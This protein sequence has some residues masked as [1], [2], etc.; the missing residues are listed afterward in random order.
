MATTANYERSLE[1]VAFSTAQ[2]RILTEVIEESGSER[3]RQLRAWMEERF[4]TKENAARMQGS[5]ELKISEMKSELGSKVGEAQ[6]GLEGKIGEV[7]RSLEARIGE[8][9]EDFQKQSAD[10][11]RWIFLF[12]IGQFAALAAILKLFK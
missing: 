8:V 2:A 7:Q 1:E 9:R 3:D 6:R 4:F 10:N 11:L 5:L 12:W